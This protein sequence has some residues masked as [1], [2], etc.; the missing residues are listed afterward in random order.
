MSEGGKARNEW[1]ERDD[2]VIYGL[3]V[4]LPSILLFCLEGID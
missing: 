2:I 1:K 4:W 3:A